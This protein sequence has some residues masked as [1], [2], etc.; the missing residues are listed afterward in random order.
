MSHNV[1]NAITFGFS[2]LCPCIMRRF[3]VSFSLRY[4]QTMNIAISQSQ[5]G[6]QSVSR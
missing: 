4:H 2:V 5:V 3:N 1:D 6:S